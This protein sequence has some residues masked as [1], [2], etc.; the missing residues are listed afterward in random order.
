MIQFVF[1][2]SIPIDDQSYFTDIYLQY[3]P[4]M[5][6]TA[7]K[8]IKD[9]NYIED[10]VQDSV[11]KLIKKTSTLRR[12]NSCTLTAYIVYT[13]RNTALNHLRRENLK[14]AHFVS[15]PENIFEYYES[16]IDRDPE[17]IYLNIEFSN[18]TWKI[19]STLPDMYLAL[20]KGKYIL[21][22]DDQE[23][24]GII[25]CKPSSVRMYLTRARRSAIELLTKGELI[26][27]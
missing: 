4:I 18:E 21:G 26:H 9:A 19:L 7:R 2:D 11:E 27:D 25:G 5:Y 24:A 8:Y 15:N 14:N 13:V 12:L 3:E 10:I 17:S 20:L 16:N 6:A 23:L 1:A 22:L